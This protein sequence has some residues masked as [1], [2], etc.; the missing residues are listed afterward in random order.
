MVRKLQLSTAK[1]L[2]QAANTRPRIKTEILVDIQDLVFDLFD[3]SSDY[4]YAD[5]IKEDFVLSGEEIDL[6]ELSNQLKEEF[7]V[8]VP[9]NKLDGMTV[10]QAM[11]YIFD[12]Y[13]KTKK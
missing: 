13:Q 4:V 3:G 12:N 2:Q 5:E 11:D 1:P 9:V 10:G 8:L 7:N 6:N